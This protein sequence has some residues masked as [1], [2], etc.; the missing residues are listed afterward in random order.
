[1]LPFFVLKPNFVVWTSLRTINGPKPG[2]QHS[3]YDPHLGLAVFGYKKE[4]LEF[5]WLIINN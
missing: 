3:A 1:M 2:Y 5:P 4:H